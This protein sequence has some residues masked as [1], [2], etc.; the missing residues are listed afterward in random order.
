[1]TDQ[2]RPKSTRRSNQ[3]VEPGPRSMRCRSATAP[4]SGSSRPRRRR[5]SHPIRVLVANSA[6]PNASSCASVTP[7]ATP[8]RHRRRARK[9]R[10]RSDGAGRP[11][12]R[13]RLICHLDRLDRRRPLPRRRRRSGADRDPD[14]NLDSRGRHHP[15]RN[16]HSAD[17]DPDRNGP[18]DRDA[19]PHPNDHP[20]ADTESGV[21]RQGRL[22][23]S[24]S[25]RHRPRLHPRGGR[26]RARDERSRHQSRAGPGV[27]AKAGGDGFHR[28]DDAGYRHRRQR[29]FRRCQ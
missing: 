23:R 16:D 28:R 10:L 6:G 4:E 13:L 27:E 25:R 22:S 15:D 8:R 20:L 17:A 12:R 18:A 5:R 19:G 2:S 9:P 1:M 11:K 14:R 29:R 21:P 26:R 24:R 7:S 3:P